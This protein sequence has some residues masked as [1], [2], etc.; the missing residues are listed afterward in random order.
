MKDLRQKGQ[1]LSQ[2]TMEYVD[3]VQG[4]PLSSPGAERDSALRPGN[5]VN[6]VDR[7]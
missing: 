7:A 1:R 6:A 4:S 5:P 3:D 2:R